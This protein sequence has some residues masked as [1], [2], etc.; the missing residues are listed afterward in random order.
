[1]LSPT[2][3]NIVMDDIL[4]EIKTK[5]K[6]L[7]VGYRNMERVL[8]SECVFA[9]DLVIFAKSERYL[10]YNLNIWNKALQDRNLRINVDK[11]KVM[12]I[13]KEDLKISIT[14]DEK[15]IEQTEIFSYLGVKIHR[16]GRNEA[17]LTGRVESALKLYHSLS[18]TF[19][20]KKEVT[21]KTKLSVYNTVF[22][23]I[24]TYGSESWILTNQMKSRIQAT[25]MKY[26][27]RVKGITRRDRVRNE[28]IR[29][30]LKVEPVVKTIERQQL[31]WLGHLVRMG[32]ER[33]PKRVWQARAA[34]K[35]TRG[36]PR[37]TWNDAVAETLR[38]RGLTW[39][40]GKRI[41]KNKREWAKF[42][43]N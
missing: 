18:N 22:K 34:Q 6:K 3:F 8:I 43:H 16:N 9:D 15:T 14:L 11:T 33:Q 27:R 1:M 30:D 24:L 28:A 35:R 31:K 2:F 20:G 13:G 5:V 19:I 26:L 4:K 38:D 39:N 32:E 41:G 25:E 10:Q 37:K 36:R 17:E 7:Q 42:V 12:V 29:K 40:D 23:P 21:T